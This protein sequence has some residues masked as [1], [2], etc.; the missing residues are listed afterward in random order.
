MSILFR[1][2]PPNNVMTACVKNLILSYTFILNMQGSENNYL[3]I[4]IQ[5]YL[6]SCFLTECITCCC[7]VVFVIKD[8]GFMIPDSLL[9]DN[10]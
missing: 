1:F 4:A 10:I 9:W 6:C 8:G 7:L 5:L 2:A 3:F